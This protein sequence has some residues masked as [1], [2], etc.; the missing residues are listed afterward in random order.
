MDDV[1][2]TVRGAH[3]IRCAPERAIAHVAAAVDGPDRADVIARLSEVAAPVRAGLDERASSG[4]VLSWHSQQVSVTAD[5]PW[6]ADGQQ[7]P[8]VYRASVDLTATFSDTE[9]LSAWL[10]ELAIADGIQV[11]HIEWALSDD[12]RAA[13]ERAAATGAVAAAVSRAEA[14]AA[15]LG[16]TE[17][18][19]LEIADV[20]L[21]RSGIDAPAPRLFAA[22]Q[23]MAADSGAFDIRP[24]EIEISAT[25]EARFRAV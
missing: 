6:S 7:L 16:R 2:I 12:T 19:P 4:V 23:E 22:K 17:V 25:V 14:Y 18:S 3:Q 24:D 21:L 13:H 11:G 8:L 1:I 20:G 15:A 9:H 5:R 10:G